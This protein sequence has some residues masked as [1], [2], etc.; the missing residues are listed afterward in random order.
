M[1]D[2]EAFSKTNPKFMTYKLKIKSIIEI[3][4]P[5]IF[6]NNFTYKI[7]NVTKGMLE[8]FSHFFIV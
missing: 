5:L 1:L 4:K 2:K 6:N 7:C 3:V 8:L